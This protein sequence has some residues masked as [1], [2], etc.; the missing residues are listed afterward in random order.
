M[1]L[2]KM[3]ELIYFLQFFLWFLIVKMCLKS[4]E[5]LIVDYLF[6]KPNE[7]GNMSYQFPVFWVILFVKFKSE[8]TLKS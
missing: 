6:W 8:L 2:W 7:H 3:L 1:V 5:L 4:S